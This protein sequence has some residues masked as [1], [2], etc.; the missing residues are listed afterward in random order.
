MIDDFAGM[1]R[2]APWLA[3]ALALAMVALIGIPPSG[4]FMAKLYIFSA[5]V[6]ADLA[7]LAV[8][9][10]INSV[11]SCLLLPAGSAHHVHHSP[12]LR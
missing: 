8:V 3:A 6:H 9:G 1:G 12:D 5:A 10:V 11:V 4:I 7:W 2:R